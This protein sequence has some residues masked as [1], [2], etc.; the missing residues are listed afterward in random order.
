MNR[1]FALPRRDGVPGFTL[2][3]LLIAMTLVSLLSVLLLGG[4]HMGTRVWERSADVADEMDEVRAARGFLRNT[5]SQAY[6]ALKKNPVQGFYVLDF[7]GS[8]SEVRFL[9]PMPQ[10]V[11]A[12]GFA[13]LTI[14]VQPGGTGQQLVALWEPEFAADAALDRTVVLLDGLSNAG[15]QYFG[16]AAG[17]PDGWSDSWTPTTIMPKL[18]RLNVRFT[19]DGRRIWQDLVVAPAISVSADCIYDPSTQGC[20]GR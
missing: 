4:L 20:A 15:F 5:I 19:Q 9:A 14:K 7:A 16:G 1:F 10:A 8:A 12:G 18:V 3:E 2:L 11:N 6:P 17:Q 13:R